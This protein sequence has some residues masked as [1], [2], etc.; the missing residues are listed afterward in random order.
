MRYICVELN[1]QTPEE[2]IW[3]WCEGCSFMLIYECVVS[4]LD[5][6]ARCIFLCIFLTNFIY[7]NLYMSF[8]I[9]LH[10]LKQRGYLPELFRQIT[11]YLPQPLTKKYTFRFFLHCTA[12]QHPAQKASTQRQG[13]P[14]L[15]DI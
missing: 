11:P 8:L 4:S 6:E 15:M 7:I 3:C 12:C 2:M 5:H 9:N 14:A 10:I 1:S 13:Q